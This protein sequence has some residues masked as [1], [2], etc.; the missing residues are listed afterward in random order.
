MGI[1]LL[2][3]NQQQQYGWQN[4]WGISTR[5]IGI[6]VMIHSDD[7]GLVLPPRVA[8]LQVVIVPIVFEDSKAA[9]L[10]EA[11]WLKKKLAAKG[12][13]VHL[14]DRDGYTPGWKFNEWE[15]KGVPIRIEIGP[16][17]LEKH[18]VLAVRRDT[19]EK[20]SLP[21]AGIETEIELLLAQIQTNLYER[22]QKKLQDRLMTVTTFNDAQKGLEDQKILFAPWC[23]TAACEEKIKEKTGAKSLNAPFQQPSLKKNQPCFACKSEAR[24]WFYFGKSY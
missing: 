21:L 9:I 7:K 23:T 24:Q 1:T 20:Q 17:D 22:A 6:M 14:D 2:D 12:L 18:Q 5:S 11:V 19:G 13:S 10:K 8:P 3:A 16:K 15:V 4:S